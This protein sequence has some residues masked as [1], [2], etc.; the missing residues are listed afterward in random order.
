[1]M[2]CEYCQSDS[3]ELCVNKGKYTTCEWVEFH[4]ECGHYERAAYC[5]RCGRKLEP[6]K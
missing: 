4:T 3:C 5:R 2:D 1:M 6:P